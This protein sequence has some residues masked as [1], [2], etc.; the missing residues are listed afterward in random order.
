MLEDHV[1]MV[2]KMENKT[3]QGRAESQSPGYYAKHPSHFRVHRILAP[4]LLQSHMVGRMESGDSK[5]SGSVPQSLNFLSNSRSWSINLL[6]LW[7]WYISTWHWHGLNTEMNV[8]FPSLGLLP[9][10][11]RHRHLFPLTDAINSNGL[12]SVVHHLY[13]QDPESLRKSSGHVCAGV[14]VGC[15]KWF[16]WKR[17]LHWDFFLCPTL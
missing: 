8:S 17:T 14:G 13:S 10:L 1:G 16:R 15:S 9:Q 12:S 2:G 11:N 5:W 4:P 7:V 6:P 3:I